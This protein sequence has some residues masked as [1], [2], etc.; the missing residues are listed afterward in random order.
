MPLKAKL[1][2]FCGKMAA[3]KSTLAILLAQQQN[4][5]LLA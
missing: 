5:V 3:G 2:L 4:A 1:F